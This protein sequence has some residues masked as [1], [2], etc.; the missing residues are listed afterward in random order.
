[1][2]KSFMSD[3]LVTITKLDA[4]QRQL[5]CAIEMWFSDR[6]LV[7]I[8]TLLS[9]SHEILH[10]LFR[11]KGLRHLLFASAA[12]RK[13]MRQEWT[14]QIRKCYNFLKHA[15]RDHDSSIL[16]NP[17]INELIIIHSIQGLKDMK[18]PLTLF[19]EAFSQWFLI[20]RTEFLPDS[21]RHGVEIIDIS[22]LRALA[23]QEFL[24]D[25]RRAWNISTQL[26]GQ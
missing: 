17:I 23:K 11:K 3:G 24:D 8:H 4:M 13:D 15:Q 10:T 20:N 19:H 16:S 7:A 5:D 22:D 1:M 2:P 6:D 25:F 9:S 18:I 21:L 12:I 26:R 14:N